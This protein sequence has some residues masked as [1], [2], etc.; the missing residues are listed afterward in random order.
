MV[1]MDGVVDDWWMATM[2][3]QG[4]DVSRRWRSHVLGRFMGRELEFI[5]T[6]FGGKSLITLN[7]VETQ[8]T[9]PGEQS[10]V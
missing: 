9:R 7:G 2:S 3:Q 1:Q 10:S 8:A 5:G 4:C 6:Q